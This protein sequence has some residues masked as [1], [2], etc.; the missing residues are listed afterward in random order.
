[1]KLPR[2]ENIMSEY[3]CEGLGTIPGGIYDT[4]RIEGV[5]SAGSPIKANTLICEGVINFSAEV[6][7]DTA[8]IEGVV[9]INGP[10]HAT[11]LDTEGVL[12]VDCIVVSDSV[13]SDG[14]PHRFFICQ[15]YKA[16]LQ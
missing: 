2:E 5:F 16:L 14:Y 8:T 6:T 15:R 3:T 7:T 4:L 12:N 9:N 13:Y 11:S 1:M 10:L